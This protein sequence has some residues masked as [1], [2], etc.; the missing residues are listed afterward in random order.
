MVTFRARSGSEV[1]YE[2]PEFSTNSIKRL[3]R[4][5]TEHRGLSDAETLLYEAFYEDALSRQV[6]VQ[7]VLQDLDLNMVFERDTNLAISGRIKNPGTLI[8]KL[9]RDHTIKLPSIHDVGGVR[10]VG[11]FLQVEQRRLAEVLGS[12]F[13]QDAMSRQS[14]IVDRCETPNQGYRA[15]HVIVFPEGKP[16]EIQIRT[17]L[18]HIWASLIEKLGDD[19]GRELRYGEP[20]IAPTEDLRIARRRFVDRLISIS[21]NEIA[22]FERDQIVLLP[23]L[24]TLGSELPPEMWEGIRVRGDEIRRSVDRARGNLMDA[25]EAA[26][27]HAEQEL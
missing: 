5:L 19:W 2:P 6:F 23:F 15:I 13:S 7:Q 10:I 17:R 9:Q 27:R 4:A 3:G 26:R 11:D 14:E 24:T 16:V 20:I 18:Q 8:D 12:F 22:D 25:L 21:T 1:T